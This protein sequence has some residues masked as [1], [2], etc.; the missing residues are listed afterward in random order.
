MTGQKTVSGRL[1]LLRFM[2]HGGMMGKK[3]GG[4][5]MIIAIVFILAV[6]LFI[7]SRNAN[8][9]QREEFLRTSSETT[10]MVGNKTMPEYQDELAQID[11]INKEYRPT[12]DR[13]NKLLEEIGTKYSVASNLMSYNSPEM[14]EVIALCEQ[15]IALLETVM[16]YDQKYNAV[17]GHETLSPAMP[18]QS[19]KRLAI[20]YEKRGDYDKAIAVCERAIRMGITKDGTEAGMIGRAARLT[21]KKLNENKKLN[22]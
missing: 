19:V 16:E 4:Y 5:I 13:H 14:E 10:L 17:R 22:A 18:Y 12:L 3:G 2:L 1:F 20:I 21:K 11:K 15:D 8:K 7:I 9:K 6:L